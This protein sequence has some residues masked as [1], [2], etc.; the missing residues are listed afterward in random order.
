[1]ENQELNTNVTQ[2]PVPP[3]PTLLN[4][5]AMQEYLHEKKKKRNLILGGV[6]VALVMGLVGFAAYTNPTLFRAA[7]TEVSVPGTTADKLYIPNY[8]AA[9]GDAGNIA[10]KAKNNLAELDG[11]TFVLTYNP[12]NALVFGA[13]P[14]VFD[15]ETLFQNAGFQ[16]ATVSEPGKLVTTIVLNEKLTADTRAQIDCADYATQSTCESYMC[17][18]GVPTAGVCQ[19]SSTL[20]ISIN[21]NLEDTHPILFKLATTINPALAV[22]QT[23]T[24]GSTDL[25]VLDGTT[26]VPVGNMATGNISFSTSATNELKVLNAEAT[27]KN[28]V[29]VS[30]N[31]YLSDIQTTAQYSLTP[32]LGITSVESG[33]FYGLDQKSVVLTT[34]DQAPGTEYALTVAS[35]VTGNTQ[36][37]VND[38]FNHALFYGFGEAGGTLSDF[39]MKSAKV[40]DYTNVEITFSEAVSSGSVTKEDFTIT[41]LDAVEVLTVTNVTGVTADKVTLTVDKPLLARNT[42]EIKAILPSAITS[43]AGGKTL[44][45]DRVAFTGSANGPKILSATVIKNA[46]ITPTYSAQFSFDQAIQVP[47]AGPLGSLYLADGTL[48]DT[49]TENDVDYDPVISGQT[50][51]LTNDVFNDPSKVFIFDITS[52]TWVKNTAGVATDEAYKS[53]Y[54][55]GFGFSAGVNSIG[56]VTVTRKDVIQVNAGNLNLSTVSAAN[57]SVHYVDGTMQTLASPTQISSVSVVSGKLQIVFA[58]P[59]AP[60]HSYILRIANGAATLDAKRF[61]VDKT[62]SMVSAQAVASN[63]VRVTFSENIDERN[64]TAADFMI[65]GVAATAF[66]LENDYLHALLTSSTALTAGTVHTVTANSDIYS[67]TG[68]ALGKKQAYFEGFRTLSAASTVKLSSAEAVSGTSVRLTF[69]GALNAS[70]V[71]PVN[72]DLI[73]F[74]GPLD[75]DQRQLLTVSSITPVNANTFD[76]ATVSQMPGVNYFVV[77]KGVTDATNLPLGNTKVLDFFGFQLPQPSL[78]GI[79]PSVITND[80]DK[81]V[82]LNGTNFNSVASVKVGNTSVTLSEKTTSSMTISIPAAFVTGVYDITLVDNTQTSYPFNDVLIVNTAVQPLTVVSGKSTSVPVNVPN[83]GTTEI[84]L[85]VLVED[86]IDLAS[87]SS[88]SV[89]LSQIG[90]ASTAQMTKDTG[91]QPLNGQWYTFKV[92]VPATVATKSEA[93]LLPVQAKKGSTV[94]NGTVSIK[95]TGD[96]YQS[97][98]PTIDQVYVSP[99]SVPPDGKTEVKISAQVTDLDGADTISSVV[100]NMGT[101]GVGFVNLKPLEIGGEAQELTTRFFESD[102]FTIPTTTALG[103]YQISVTAS[104][105]TGDQDV[106]QIALT[107]SNTLTGPKINSTKSYVTPFKSIPND[108]KTPFA[109]Y[110][111][112]EDPDGVSDI[113]SVTGDFGALGLAPKS[114]LKDPETPEDAKAAWYS[115][116][117]LTIPT[118]APYGTHDIEITAVDKSGG[119]AN[120]IIKIEA[121]FKDVNGSAP[122]IVEDKGYTTPAV[123][124]NDGTTPVT[125]YAFVQDDDDDLESVVVNLSKIGQVGKANPTDF[126]APAATVPTQAA[127]PTNSNVLVCMNPSVR[128]GDEGQWYILPG[129]TVSSTTS[130]SSAPYEIDVIATDKGSKTTYGKLSVY[131]N[132]GKSF[133]ND[134]KPPRL[135]A[136]VPTAATKIEVLFNEELSAT[137]VSANGSN[138]TVADSNDITKILAVTAAT[139]NSAGNVVTLTTAPQEAGKTYVLTA[140]TSIRDAVGVP[141]VTGSGSKTSFTGFKASGKVPILE[142][143]TATGVDQVELEFRDPLQPSSVKTLGDV[144]IQVFESESG[145]ALPVKSISFGDSAKKLLVT[146]DFM[147]SNFGYRIQVND[148]ASF[149]GKSSEAGLSQSFKGYNLQAAQHAAA[150]GSADLNG[151]GNVDFIDFTIFS[152]FYGTSYI[153]PTS[154]GTDSESVTTGQPIPDNPDALV[155]ITS[156]P[157]GGVTE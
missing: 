135:T 83:D 63:Q 48:I 3:A 139:I 131:V 24:L 78:A 42:Y 144:G 99:L 110:A 151:D 52:P 43:N 149:D 101:L 91:T 14:I 147:K 18:W 154:S 146:T 45:I 1:M 16:M 71:T 128:E 148:V 90:G 138:F 87:V 17:T 157:E 84:T 5:A 79:V 54:F 34:A 114:L 98:A 92:K 26:I 41:N 58:A 46:N 51:L 97:V 127:C 2:T 88:V 150:A 59:L 75:P 85:W 134:S 95:V 68:K 62:L 20:P 108:G 29:V 106:E 156:D 145:K 77:F 137:S 25:A 53:I 12:T 82:V 102:T 8:S 33:T 117:G 50:I 105:K 9:P 107:V 57:V 30:F 119:T 22:G 66:T 38:A 153:N 23:I 89:D 35:A 93:Y 11:F 122:R 143:V 31:D 69:S 55:Y 116:S 94:A 141:L 124:V 113:T 70:T 111:F 109:I 81:L 126:G 86:P 73:R 47:A 4:Q 64:V 19:G 121:T 6:V 140:N 133:E 96:V 136:A 67:Y 13:N 37:G 130:P 27:N 112:V 129:V 76:L 36:G 155:P 49:I 65:D 103:P 104:D 72:I 132:D 100:A 56:G 44:G 152:S 123:A 32:P 142:Y 10:I 28:R 21:P 74:I 15:N 60:N 80:S 120:L 40:T 39:T 61:T 7:I 115:V 125:L 118:T